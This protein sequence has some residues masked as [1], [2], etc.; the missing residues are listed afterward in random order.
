MYKFKWWYGERRQSKRTRIKPQYPMDYV[1]PD[2]FDIANFTIDSCYKVRDVPKSH[3]K[4]IVSPDSDR[5]KLA[6]EEEIIA[7]RENDTYVLTTLPEGQAVIGG[8]WVY[9]IKED[10]INVEKFKARFVAK[11]YSQ[12]ENVNYT[13]TF[14]LQHA[15]LLLGCWYNWQSK[16][17]ILFFKWMSKWHI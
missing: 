12:I 16:I 6:M 15:S 13:E 14:S 7:L 10:L 11:G 2:E 5:R 17:G 8:R 4:V 1:N 3:I 9:A